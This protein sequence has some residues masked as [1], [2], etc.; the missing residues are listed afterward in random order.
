MKIRLT[1]ALALLAAPLAAQTGRVEYEIAFPNAAQ[2]EAEVTA[3]FRGA[4]RGQPL[5]VRMSRSSPG[6]YALGNFAKNVYDVRATDGAGRPLRVSR[7]DAHGW[8][9]AGHD[10][11]VR[12]RYT[13]WG[14][15]VDGTYLGIDRSHAHLNMPATFAWARVMERAPVR[16]TVRPNPGWRVATQLR[17]TA[18]PA[19]FTAPDLQWFMDSPVEVGPVTVREW[20]GTHGGRTST[21]R[22]AVHHLGTAAQVDSFTAMVRRVVDEQIAIWGEP[23]AYD[24]GVY[25][26]IADYLPWAARDGMEHRNST[27]LTRPGSLAGEAERLALLGTVS[28]EFFHSWNMER[29]RSRALEPFDLENEDASGELWLGEGFTRYY[30]QLTLRRAGFI[31]D[32][33]YAGVL[34]GLAN[35]P[36]TAPGW[37]RAPLVEMSMRAPLHDGFVSPD[38][39]NQQNVHVS[40][41]AGGAST[42]LALDLMLRTRFGRTLDDYM[43]LLWRR[44]GR[45]QTPALAPANPYTLADLRAALAEVAGDPAFAA[46]F[47]RRHV[48]G[49]ET[50][51]YD[52]LLSAAGFRVVKAAPGQP[53]L[54]AP[55]ADD[56]ASVRVGDPLQTGSLYPAGITGGDR[57]H[58]VD[59]EPTPT[60]A[61]LDA[62]LA[63]HRPGD[64]VRM[65][66]SG[67][68]QRFTVPVTLRERP[69][70]RVVPVDAPTEAQLAFRRSWL[71]SRVGGS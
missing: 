65:E 45:P 1:L 49:T 51:D 6:R 16:L 17:P 38:P 42:A 40:H 21:W 57:I 4:P 32:S 61:A 68:G 31:T 33:A 5:R 47:F 8:D 15:R 50:A 18:D 54:G 7:P 36:L 11:T 25:T 3:V 66:V 27:V 55:L 28:H 9:V 37:R 53:F 10:G 24:H 34:S 67:R 44:H 41:Y 13:V 39:T 12:V 23:A 59:G 56:T 43:R 70:V 64:V 46:D 35:T 48:E 22:V 52:R 71:G 62:L 58:A 2:H 60:A 20:S 26:F 14:D 29:L 63:R 30:D 19:V 69:D